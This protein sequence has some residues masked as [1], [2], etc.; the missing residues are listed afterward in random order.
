V[1]VEE[2]EDLCERLVAELSRKHAH[3]QDL[4][5]R[6]RCAREIRWLALRTKRRQEDIMALVERLA[7]LTPAQVTD[8]LDE[9][10]S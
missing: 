8:L 1:R 4:Q 5:H 9:V 7:V 10:K 2:L 6:L 3:I